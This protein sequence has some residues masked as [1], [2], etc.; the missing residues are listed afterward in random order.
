MEIIRRTP[1][2][3]VSINRL[4]LVLLMGLVGISCGSIQFEAAPRDREPT[5]TPTI[6]PVSIGRNPNV[7]ALTAAKIAIH[8][9]TYGFAPL[10]LLPESR[11]ALTTT[12]QGETRFQLTYPQQPEDVRRWVS[13]DS[14]VL[15]QALQ[16]QLAQAEA[17]SQ[18]SIGQLSVAAPINDGLSQVNHYAVWVNF[19]D[20]SSTIVDLSPLAPDFGAYYAG[21]HQLIS[22]QAATALFTNRQTSVLLDEWQPMSIVRVGE[23]WYYLL[24]KAVVADSRYNFSLQAHQVQLGTHTESFHLS[25]GSRAEIS[26][27]QADF[28]ALQQ[29]IQADGET[30][31]NDQP[32]L[33]QQSGADDFDL[34]GVLHG[35]LTLLWH[36]VTK[37]EINP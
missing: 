33:W 37:V 16:H 6:P 36:L 29:L 7:D 34:R 28:R 24:A 18:A 13:V 32:D 1:P 17:V 22:A 15:A 4:L 20:G 10:L 31:F 9:P 30:V 3:F 14:F 12:Q 25:R 19:A 26:L 2:P 23:Q 21:Y 27:N 5:A 35:N 8:N 11:L